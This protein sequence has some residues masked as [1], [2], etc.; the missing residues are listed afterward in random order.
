[1]AWEELLLTGLRWTSQ[2]RPNTQSEHL[3]ASLSFLMLSPC[4]LNQ[5]S[6]YSMS[7]PKGIPAH[8]YPDDAEY[9]PRS[10]L[11]AQSLVPDA[12]RESQETGPQTCLS[13]L[14]TC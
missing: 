9:V 4:T 8:K 2:K 3:A 14:P 7:R 13:S 11:V 10:S 5:V 1:M 12:C 6:S